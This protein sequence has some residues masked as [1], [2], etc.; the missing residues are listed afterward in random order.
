MNGLLALPEII[1]LIGACSILMLHV[2]CQEKVQRWIYLLAQLTLVLAFFSVCQLMN[3]NKQL[4]FHD[5]FIVDHLAVLLKF[6]LL[7]LTGFVFVYSRDYV[8]ETL[9]VATKQGAVGE[10]YVLSLLSVLGMMVLISGQN[11]ITLFLGLELLSLPIYA[12]VALRRKDDRALESATKY[13]I[14]G[15]L[16]SALLLYGFSL[17]YGSCGALDLSKIASIIATKQLMHNLMLLIGLVFILIAVLFK[18]GAAPFHSWVPDV[19]DGAP[20]SVTLFVASVPKLAVLAMLFRLLDDALPSLSIQWHEIL[21][22]ISVLSIGLGNIV[23]LS[24]KNLKRLF[25]YSSIAHIGYMLLGFVAGTLQ[26]YAASVFY[27]ISY[28]MMT[29]AALG[30]LTIMNRRGVCIETIDDIKGLN[31]RH[32]WFAFL[33]LLILFSMA[34]I[35]PLVGFMAKLSVLEALVN[36]GMIWLVVV[37]LLFAIVGAYYYLNLVKVMYFEKNDTDPMPIKLPLDVQIAIAIN[38]I[39]LLFLGIFPSVLFNACRMIFLG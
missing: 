9:G 15:A 32:S 10:Y 26:G 33:W 7:L 31:Q 2:C 1:I 17:V 38:S 24:Q 6:M 4:A 22:L 16:A 34:G 37:A 39:L 5:L 23:A 28:V 35:P 29:T 18:L 27:M 8:I 12:L 3:V 14:M 11:L 19:Y 20:M 13:F 21:I 25:A 30:L 36:V